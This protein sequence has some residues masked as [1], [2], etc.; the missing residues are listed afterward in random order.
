MAIRSR[1]GQSS[2]GRRF[3]S[4][5]DCREMRGTCGCPFLFLRIARRWLIGPGTLLQI[6]RAVSRPAVSSASGRIDG[7]YHRTISNLTF[8]LLKVNLR[9]LEITSSNLANFR[10]RICSQHAR[11]SWRAGQRQRLR[12]RSAVR[13]RRQLRADALEQSILEH[14]Q[15]RFEW[16]FVL[17]GAEHRLPDLELAHHRAEPGGE[18]HLCARH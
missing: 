14:Q 4:N 7:D 12:G 13:R 16:R 6:G 18:L 11:C 10:A 17:R 8:Q 2:W 1:G 9:S 3:T 15:S 5:P